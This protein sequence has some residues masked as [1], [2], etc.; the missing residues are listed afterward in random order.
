MDSMSALATAATPAPLFTSTISVIRTATVYV[1][2]PATFTQPSLILTPTSTTAT[3]LPAP[4][5]TNGSYGAILTH[6]TATPSGPTATIIETVP[7][8]SPPSAPLLVLHTGGIRHPNGEQVKTMWVAGIMLIC[9]L[10]SWN[11]ILL[12]S[13]LH[14]YKMLINLIHES[15]H[16]FGMSAGVQGHKQAMRARLRVSSLKS[17]F[18]ASGHPY[19]CQRLFVRHNVICLSPPELIVNCIT[20]IPSSF[21]ITI[22]PDKGPIS[23]MTDGQPHLI[24]LAGYT[25]SILA[26]SVMIMSGFDTS[27]SKV[28]CLSLFPL[29]VVCFWFGRTWARMRIMACVG[30]SVAFWF[31]E[32]D[33]TCAIYTTAAH[34]GLIAFF[35][36]LQSTRQLICA[37]T[38]YS[39]EW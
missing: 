10:V 31:S 2:V 8:T 33:C 36:P 20:P 9:I 32:S 7:A 29:F 19:G 6:A 30:L 12:R 22:D 1:T 26:G 14:P 3:S 15:G 38:S 16:V 39:S 28:A 4:V 27:A 5:S 18:I 37:I 35:L 21:R 17:C 23:G 34:L 24:L 25:T 13:M 11:M